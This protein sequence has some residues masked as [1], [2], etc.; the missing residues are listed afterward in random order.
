MLRL[1]GLSM[2][3]RSLVLSAGCTVTPLYGESNRAHVG[4]QL[5]KIAVDKIDSRLGYFT[6]Q[7]VERRLNYKGG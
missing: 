7:E 6:Q 3:C 2:L 4:Q 5:E 1:I